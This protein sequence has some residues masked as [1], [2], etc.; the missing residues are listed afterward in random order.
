MDNI[1]SGSTASI[2]T[3]N[4]SKFI[5]VEGDLG[6]GIVVEWSDNDTNWV[7]LVSAPNEPALLTESQGVI[8]TTGAGFVR[9]LMIGTGNC[10]YAIS[11]IRQR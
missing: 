7:P 6:G 9:L 8:L 3:V 11:D 1:T 2:P 5:A 4:G 10:N